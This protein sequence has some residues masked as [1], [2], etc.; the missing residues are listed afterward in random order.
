MAHVRASVAAALSALSLVS[1]SDGG[2]SS[3][4]TVTSPILEGSASIAPGG[5]SFIPGSRL[6]F[7]SNVRPDLSTDGLGAWVCAWSAHTTS[8]LPGYVLAS[9]SLDNG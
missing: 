3:S 4:S 2:G 6:D 8:S 5:P 1:C 9:R 7:A